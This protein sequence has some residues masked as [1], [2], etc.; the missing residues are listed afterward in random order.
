MK[1]AAC[2]IVSFNY[3]PYARVLCDSFLATHPGR[4]FHVLLVDRMPAG[5]DASQE[6]FELLLVEELEIPD[7]LSMAFKYDILE[8]NTNVKPTFLKYLLSRG[9]EDLVYLDPDIFVFNELTPIFDALAD[10]AIV[11]TPHMLSPASHEVRQELILLSAGVFNLGFIAVKRCP[12]TDRFLLWWEQRCLD[13]AFNEQRAGMFVDQKWIDF[14]PCFFDSVHILK[15]PGCNMAYW[16]LHERKLSG[17]NGAWTVN[18]ACP[19]LFFHFSGV[20]VDG[21]ERISKFTNHQMLSDRPDLCSIFDDYRAALRRHGIRSASGSRYAFASFDNGQ[22]IHRLCRS[23]YAANL[24]RFRGEDPFR[25]TGRFYLWANRTGLLSAGDAAKN[26]TAAAYS[27]ENILIRAI[28]AALRA[29]LRILGA[30]RYTM[31]M[32]YLSHVSILRN[33]KDVFRAG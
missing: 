11:I 22:P 14:V 19:L 13:L 15:H 5:Y 1:Q 8:L 31:L 28:H 2:T 12:E 17:E 24:D 26:Y 33:Q 20:S 32:K 16:N 3:L 4:S 29:A 7:F 10:S 9:I 21:G 23:I 25:S 27:K 30:D 18:H 6:P